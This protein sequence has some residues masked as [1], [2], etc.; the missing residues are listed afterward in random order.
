MRLRSDLTLRRV[1]DR[2][3]LV[4][5]SDDDLN[6]TAVHTFNSTAAF[7]WQA[8]ADCGCDPE[9]LARRLCDDYDVDFATA[10]SDTRRI[11]ADWQAQ[12]LLCE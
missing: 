5:V 3:M 8:A 11:L 4:V 6:R 7:L 10:L 12:G 1:G 9:A 2:Y